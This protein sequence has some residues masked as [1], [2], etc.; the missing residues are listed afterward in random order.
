MGWQYCVDPVAGGGSLPR[1]SHA[2]SHA[3][4]NSAQLKAGEL[5]TFSTRVFKTWFPWVIEIA[6]GVLTWKRTT[7]NQE[8]RC[9]FK[10]QLSLLKGHREAGEKTGKSWAS[11]GHV[12]RG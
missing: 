5:L 12:P 7:I 1:Q 11:V 3:A 4:H 2:F 9:P 6:E 10:N 8:N